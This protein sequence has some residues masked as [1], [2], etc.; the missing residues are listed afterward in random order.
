MSRA[1]RWLLPDGVKEV[2][3]PEAA[4]IEG[5]RRTVVDQYQAW[6]YD[7]VMP[8]LIEYIDSLLI[9]TGDDLDLATFKVI[10]QKTGRTMG[11]RADIT[12]QVA[13]I[14][15]HSLNCQGINRLCYS[16]TV[17]HTS[18]ANP[19]A[20]RSPLQVGA[21]LYGHAGIE[22]DLEV[23]SLMLTT[24]TSVDIKH[25]I[26]LDLGHVGIYRGLI[27][28]IELAEDDERD[29][30]NLLQ[31]K[32][33]ADIDALVTAM[34]LSEQSKTMLQ[35]LPRLYGDTQILDQ[36]QQV[37][38]EV[39]AQVSEAIAYLRD[40]ANAISARFPQV[41]LY[42]DLAELRGYEYHTGV[43]FAAL[44]P[45]FGQAIAKGGRYDD[46][47]QVFGRA[48]PATGFS[49]DLKILAELSDQPQQQA[50]GIAMPLEANLSADQRQELWHTQTQLRQ[51]GQRLV[52]QL[53]QQTKPE[54]CSQQLVWENQAWVIEAL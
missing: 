27:D 3:P 42:F 4:R 36:A 14:D 1:N 28:A 32:A 30:F 20:S 8:P 16:N 45:A 10:D 48:R 25:P 35:Q 26:T 46:I 39:S 13:R 43:V 34:D 31:S 29:L 23:I 17:L 24:L 33:V 50:D 2:L 44:T 15:A 38:G 11:I 22:S 7:L 41:T 52:A 53:E 18:A 40:L 21:E 19:L 9:G 5:L 47:G 54:Q 51:Q 6:G 49:A 37:F 12:P